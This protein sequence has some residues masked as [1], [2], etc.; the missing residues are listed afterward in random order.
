MITTAGVH[1]KE[2]P[3]G[4][5]GCMARE[6]QS[7]GVTGVHGRERSSGVAGVQDKTSV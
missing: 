4:V 3:G 5:A 7:G 6:G 2:R 1:G